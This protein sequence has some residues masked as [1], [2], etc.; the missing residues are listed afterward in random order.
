MEKV[1]KISHQELKQIKEMI[2]EAFVT[3]E[4]FHEFG[5][6]TDRRELVMKYMDAYVQ[7]VY[8]SGALYRTK[9]GQGY[10]GLVFSKDTSVFPKIKMLLRLLCCIP[11]KTM[12]RYL[13]H[14]KQIAGTN[15]RYT[16]HPHVDV[17]MVCVKKESQ[18]KGIARKLVE[19]AQE[20]A[21][22]LNVPLL[23]DTDMSDYAKM[24]Q[25]MGCILYN[26]VTADNGVTRYS[27]VW[28]NEK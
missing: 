28:E 17:L 24:Y 4:L 18:G 7:F 3:N 25:H 11:P 1:E 26:E 21:G 12:K 8:E 19:Y 14:V 2:G 13:N 9:D 10:I 27:L 6:I 23:F 22:D 15:E 16:K 5:S 20:M